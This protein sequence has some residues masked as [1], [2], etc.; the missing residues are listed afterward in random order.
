MAKAE[1]RTYPQVT[2]TAADL[3][4]GAVVAAPP[5][6][7]ASDGLRLARRRRV[8]VLAAG[9]GFVL[10]EDLARAETLGVGDLPLRRLT[11]PLP[12]LA[13]RTGEIAV[14]RALAAGAAAVVVL[15]GRAPMG[16]VRRAP[17]PAA[18]SMQARLARVL[19]AESLAL[20]SETGRLAA[21][22]GA[23]AYVVG[24]LVRDAW[25]GRAPARHDLDVA[26]EG[27]APAVARAL[28]AARHGTLV[29]HERFLTASVTLPGGRRLDLVTA[30]SERYEGDGSLPRVLP[31]AMAQDL[32][33]R[34]FT[35]NA[36]A[37]ELSSGTFGLLDPLGG[38]AD[39][40]RRTL[41]VLHPLSFVED[42]TRIFRAARY[43]ARLGFRLDAWSAD[44]RALALERAPYAELS[45]ARIVAEL[46]HILADAEPA[47]A[48]GALARAGAFRLLDPRHRAGRAVATRLT[49]VPAALGWARGRGLTVPPLELLAAALAAGQP[50]EVAA[51]VLR[52]LG[53][54]GAPLVRVR[55]ALD[56]AR[57]LAARLDAAARAS[58]AARL[59]RGSSPTALAWL[60]LEGDTGARARLERRL[61]PADAGRP[62]LGG[63][64]VIALGVAR[65]PGVARVLG[66]LRDA[67]LDGEIRDRQGEI[68]YVKSWLDRHTEREG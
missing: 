68:D 22:G 8:E 26:I 14:R 25:L 28:A 21:A 40:A 27:D 1:G 39:V 32:R 16:V 44:C 19:D 9:R 2:P 66:A 61:A 5:A 53:L 38:A 34:D 7:S 62:E 48:L 67:R 60:H 43:A 18:I 35:V 51:A 24:G 33:R 52:R 50:P 46:E 17:P 10:R 59:L 30:R 23:T 13:A 64:A 41:R 47:R 57:D 31:A 29:E 49:R 36:M 20:L 54:G 63:E 42:P 6:L 55:A 4:D 15:S 3:I 37:A 65:G 56:G 45:P 12:A 58:E 11:R